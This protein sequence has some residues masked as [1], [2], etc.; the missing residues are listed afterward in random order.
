MGSVFLQS[1]KAMVTL[2]SFH[3]SAPFAKRCRKTAMVPLSA[4]IWSGVFPS[5]SAKF[6]SAPDLS[7]IFVHFSPRASSIRAEICNGASP[8]GPPIKGVRG[9]VN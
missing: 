6:V 7:N 4:D 3:G 1:Y 5:D 2:S 8:M 9:L